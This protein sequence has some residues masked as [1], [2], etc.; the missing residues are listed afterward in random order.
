MKT[1][2][3]EK[4]GL[5]LGT[6]SYDETSG[7]TLKRFCIRVSNTNVNAS[8]ELKVSGDMVRTFTNK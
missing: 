3:I 7:E 5:S 8:Y 6:F 1:L 2:T 4:N